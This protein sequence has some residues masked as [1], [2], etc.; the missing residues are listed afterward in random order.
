[1]AI[2]EYAPPSQVDANGKRWTS[3]HIN[4]TR[5]K[6]LPSWWYYECDDKQC[7]HT[8]GTGLVAVLSPPKDTPEVKPEDKPCPSCGRAM[9]ARKYTTPIFGFSTSW[10]DKPRRIGDARP[11]HGYTSKV[12]YWGISTK[13]EA[14]QQEL[15]NRSEYRFGTRSV[16]VFYSPEG[17]LAVMNKGKTG[18]G[19]FL[20]AVCGYVFE[21]PP[22]TAKERKHN[23]K[24]GKEC[25]ENYTSTVLG[26]TLFT[27]ILQIELPDLCSDSINYPDKRDDWSVLYAILNG[28]SDELEITRSDIDGC[29]H[30]SKDGRFLILFDSAAGGAG[31]VKQ[32]FENIEKVLINAMSRIDD[33]CGCSPETSCYGCLRDYGNQ[34]THEQLT[35]GGAYEYLSRLLTQPGR[36][37][38]GVDV[39]VEPSKAF[40]QQYTSWSHCAK[41][42]ECAELAA[43]DALEVPDPVIAALRI[44]NEK[45]KDCLVWEEQRVAVTDEDI[46]KKAADAGWNCVAADDLVAE[47]LAEQIRGQE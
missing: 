34:F 45:I 28:A 19:M 15:Q 26:H 41:S 35:R 2:A 5:D 32:I 8:E 33:L 22:R 6:G 25:N 3:R 7:R 42:W 17:Q 10:S 21:T 12:Q 9:K 20:C 46:R 43:F 16:S 29:V 18:R 36:R 4:L 13:I 38:D 14:T 39:I 31:H 40:R 30:H 24:H 27:D 11:V 47:I 44:G 1:M 23:N 37:I